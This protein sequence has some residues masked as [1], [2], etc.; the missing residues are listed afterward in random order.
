MSIAQE[1][2]SKKEGIRLNRYLANSGV[3]I[4][5]EAD[6]LIAKGLVEV[7]GKVVTEMGYKVQR[8]EKVTFQGVLQNAE[9][10]KYIL[11]NKPK[12]HTLSAKLSREQRSVYDIIDNACY[13]E[14]KPA[15]E[16]DINTTGVLLMT[17]DS[18]LVKK[19]NLKKRE[20]YHLF[21]DKEMTDEDLAK[22]SKGF[23]VKSG[24]VKVEAAHF[25]NEKNKKEVGIELLLGQK[26]T[27]RQLVDAL[28]Y[29]LERLDRVV[30]AGLT[31]KNLPRG[32]W[33]FLS[34]KEVQFLKMQ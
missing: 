29:Q 33:R 6:K 18:E 17:N 26:N 1:N 3:C 16:L 7:D 25:A 19:M 24:F 34:T 20:I 23:K 32:K 10:K 27:I 2:N 9:S 21:L 4:R 31:K 28:G 13:E 14:V 22:L 11:V 5:R 30:Y 15:D 12:E 8:G